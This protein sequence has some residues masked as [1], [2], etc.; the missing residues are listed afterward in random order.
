MAEALRR[1]QPG[2]VRALRLAA[3]YTQHA[4]ARAIGVSTQTIWLVDNDRQQPSSALLRKL[5]RAL[6]RVPEPLGR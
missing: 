5:R 4:L 2:R 6:S 1:V 3:R